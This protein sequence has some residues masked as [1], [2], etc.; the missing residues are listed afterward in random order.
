M[1][2]LDPDENPID[3]PL[4]DIPYALKRG[5]KLP[6]CIITLHRQ[7]TS[8]DYGKSNG[9]VNMLVWKHSH[10]DKLISLLH[11]GWVITL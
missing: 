8:N 3:I 7:P 10:Y 2:L 1:I 4:E 6:T 9:R 11:A 5:F